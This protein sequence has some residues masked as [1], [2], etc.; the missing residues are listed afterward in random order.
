MLL[1]KVVLNRTISLNSNLA[2]KQKLFRNIN[3]KSS[4]SLKSRHLS[5]SSS[6]ASSSSGN[7]S[8]ANAKSEQKQNQVS[9]IAFE[10]Y[11]DYDPN[12]PQGALGY[13]TIGFRL[14]LIAFG[15]GCMGLTINELIPKRMSPNKLYSDAFEAV[16]KDDK[17]KSI[18]GDD[19]KAYGRSRRSPVDSR[20]Y[21]V[22]KDD[23]NRTRV[24]FNVE[25]KRGH[26]LVYA[27]VSIN[28]KITYLSYITLFNICIYL[29][30]AIR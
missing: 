5:T 27:E 30:I 25:G 15:L 13:A 2:S 3:I 28:N 6:A 11:D 20:T 10:D 22:E 18:L 1:S 17:I 21:K 7:Q 14:L 16:K 4:Y 26:M 12:E 8:T 24:R 9:K 23:S 29:I 19:M